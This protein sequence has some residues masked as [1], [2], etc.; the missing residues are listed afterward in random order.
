MAR[1]ANYTPHEDAIILA[2][3]G[4]PFEQTNS[5]LENA[6]FTRRTKGQISGRRQY[7]KFNASSGSNGL[8]VLIE[9]REAL[10]RQR[11]RI[12]HALAE[13][14]ELL[15]RALAQAQADLRGG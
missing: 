1:P 14:N 6:G 2:T 8:H 15:A 4:L 9:R 7:L 5:Q 10:Q 3:N 13:T 11:E 12:D